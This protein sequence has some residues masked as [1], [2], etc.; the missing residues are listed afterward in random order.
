MND[1]EARLRTMLDEGAATVAADPTRRQRTMRRSRTHR[2]GTALL[3]AV[4][5][6]GVVAG[7]VTVVGTFAEPDALRPAQPD[8]QDGG[9]LD[10]SAT[11]TNEYPEI[12]RGSLEGR[13]WVLEGR[14]GQLGGGMD[15]L[16]LELVI[17]AAA[18]GGEPLSATTEV[19]PGD[20]ELLV[21]ELVVPDENARAVFGATASLDGTH[22]VEAVLDDG[23]RI[24]GFIAADYDIPIDITAQYFVMFV[25]ADR[26]G[27][28]YARDRHGIDREQEPIG[29]AP[30]VDRE[31]GPLVS[32][33]FNGLLWAVDSDRRGDEICLRIAFD[34]G[35]PADGCFAEERAGRL[36]LRVEEMGRGAKALVGFMP[37]DHSNLE[38]TIDGQTSPLST[39]FPP[40][41]HETLGFPFAVVVPADAH[42]SVSATTADGEKVSVDF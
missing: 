42:G 28:V 21:Q 32:G 37:F 33:A 39:P 23:T 3:A 38:V 24:S 14:R 40:D 16:V 36:I 27:Y 9:P 31:T 41:P 7:G 17:E 15:K 10:W 18:E 11:L 30:E 29:D 25:P 6:V 13:E 8:Q 20:D 22:S 1:L 2:A 5:L 26:D 34:Q 35:A 4:V 12:A 19:V